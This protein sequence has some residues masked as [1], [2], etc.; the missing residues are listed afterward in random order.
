MGRSDSSGERFHRY[1]CRP[2][3]GL[4]RPASALSIL[5]LGTGIHP[6]LSFELDPMPFSLSRR[7]GPRGQAMV[8]FAAV[9]L[10]VLFVIVG[11]VQFGLLLNANVTITNAAREGARAATIYVYTTD[12]GS[13]RATNDIDRCTAA[14]EAGTRAFGILNAASPN[15]TGSAS[16]SS[17]TDLNGDGLHDQWVNGDL[18]ISIC[19]RMATSTS[20]CPNSLD[21]ASYCGQTEPEGCL[22]RVEIT[23]R[24]DI[25]VPL[26]SAVLPT[27][28]N[29]R[30]VQRAVAT[31]VIN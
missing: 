31:M 24:S 8:E 25:I 11:I 15:F 26:I 21:S 3:N 18:N 19:A 10:P 7:Q 28:S 30:F 20:S 4:Y 14:R 6:G 22:V 17:G 12:G 9:L 27:D 1:R 13:T 5:R 29:G 16:C 2:P 23:Y